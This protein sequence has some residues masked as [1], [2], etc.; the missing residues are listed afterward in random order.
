MT[1]DCVS[2]GAA[3]RDAGDA[4]QGVENKRFGLYQRVLRTT[5]DRTAPPLVENIQ[6]ECFY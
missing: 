4:Q 3:R 2:V 6:T 5:Q 1:A